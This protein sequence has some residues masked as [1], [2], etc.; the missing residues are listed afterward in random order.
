MVRRGI[1]LSYEIEA[2]PTPSGVL[3][4]LPLSP[5]HIDTDSKV[6]PASHAD[7]VPVLHQIFQPAFHWCLTE[8]VCFSYGTQRI[9]SKR[10]IGVAIGIGEAG[11]QGTQ[12]V[13]VECGICC[14]SNGFCANSFTYRAPGFTLYISFFTWFV[15]SPVCWSTIIY[16]FWTLTVSFSALSLNSPSPPICIYTFCYYQ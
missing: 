14:R 13:L 9:G 3:G 2:R 4:Y 16:S 7:Q 1:R 15:T 8:A 10:D 6:P 5:Y 12:R 11:C